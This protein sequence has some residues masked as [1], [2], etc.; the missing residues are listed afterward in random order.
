M[1]SFIRKK[2][3]KGHEYLYEI[4]PY[5]DSESGKWKQKSRYLG[6]NVEGKPVKK[7]KPTRLSHIFDLGQY[8]PAY[9]AV[10]EYKILEALIS[11]CSPQ[12][13]ATLVVLAINRM[14]HP[15]PPGNLMTWYTGTCMPFL[16]PNVDMSID[17]VV[18]TLENV[19]DTPATGMFARMFSLINRLSDQRV[20]MTLQGNL[21]CQPGISSTGPEIEGCLERDLMMRLHYDPIINIP[22]G[23]D[24]FPFQKQSIEDS[25]KQ[26]KSGHIPGGIILPNWDYMS[27]SL[28]PL[29][30]KSE[31]PF[32]MRVN[33]GYEPLA[34][35]LSEF[36]GSS[37]QWT[38]IKYYQGQACY[39]NPF[40]SF[41]KDHAVNGYILH[42]IKKEQ[43]DRL[44]FYKN[45]QNIRELIKEVSTNAWISDET[46]KHVSGPFSS[47]FS[48][49]EKGEI[50]LIRWNEEAINQ[51]LMQF[52]KDGVLYQGEL[53][54]ES[55]FSLVD[56]KSQFE[57]EING[58]INQFE[59]DYSDFRT[60]RMRVG[61]YFVAFLTFQIRHLIEN[62]IKTIKN[63][64]AASFESL[65]AELTPIHLIKNPGYMVVPERL[66]REQKVLLSFFGGIPSLLDV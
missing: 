59:R 18:Q 13:A 1:K 41:I 33:L 6:K 60:D 42:N 7:E 15:C 35:H 37:N 48:R 52:G 2:I 44:L 51:V 30:C 25:I 20:L 56:L 36:T 32:I 5:F 47:F 21:P 8:I 58:Y 50:T 53:T 55:C 45:L 63:K 16:L 19:S 29:M 4:T 26:V 38:N 49:E 64:S 12:E 40:T 66:K 34:P 9:W 14:I 22:V 3:I 62:R 10:H 23:C 27:P 61:I 31:C 54:W 28:I 43:S 11:C 46:L 39:V 24:F 65:I 57:T 17:G